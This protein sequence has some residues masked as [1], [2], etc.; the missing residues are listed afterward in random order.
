MKDVVVAFI[1]EHG[2][3]V[4]DAFTTENEEVEYPYPWLPRLSKH[5]T[6]KPVFGSCVGGKKGICYRHPA[7][8]T[9]DNEL[10]MGSGCNEALNV[11]YSEAKTAKQH[12]IDHNLTRKST[13]TPIGSP[14]DATAI[15]NLIAIAKKSSNQPTDTSMDADGTDGNDGSD[16][17]AASPSAPSI[18]ASSSAQLADVLVDPISELSVNSIGLEDIPSI[19]DTG[20]SQPADF[21]VDAGGTDGNDVWDTV[22]ASP[23]MTSIEDVNFER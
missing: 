4:Y 13:W 1:K 17:A 2:K 15:K 9:Y 22:A 10:S 20:L 3:D 5:Q 19:G 11:W 23:S 16:T 18:E 21:T 14:F 12:A 7:N 8:D 6:Q